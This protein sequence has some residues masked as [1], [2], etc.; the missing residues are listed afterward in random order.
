MNGSLMR[1]KLSCSRSLHILHGAILK[2]FIHQKLVE[3]EKIKFKKLNK[4][5]YKTQQLSTYTSQSY[6][7]QST[8]TKMP[9]D[10]ITIFKFTQEL[11]SSFLN[12]FT[13]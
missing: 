12:N 6:T 9:Y 11:L 5:N 3:R 13:G 8:N 1:K 2:I 10:T 7:T 4:L